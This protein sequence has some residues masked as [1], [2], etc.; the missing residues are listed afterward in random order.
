MEY[1]DDSGSEYENY[2]MCSRRVSLPGEL[3]FDPASLEKMILKLCDA[4]DFRVVMNEER[5]KNAMLVTTGLTLAGT[6][7]GKHYGGKLGA[8]LGGAVGGVCG[9]GI[10]GKS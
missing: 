6:I 1:S 5:S 4:F 10:V 7:I 8:A 9:L 3:P 2:E